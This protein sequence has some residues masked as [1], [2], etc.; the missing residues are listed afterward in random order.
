MSEVSCPTLWGLIAT[1]DPQFA[2][3]TWDQA[4][5]SLVGPAPWMTLTFHRPGKGLYSYLIH[6]AV[7]G[8]VHEVRAYVEAPEHSPMVPREVSAGGVV[9]TRGS[10][11]VWRG[12]LTLDAFLDRWAALEEAGLFAGDL[13]PPKPDLMIDQVDRLDLH[14][15]N[16][17][18][19]VTFTV[20]GEIGA[21][22]NL[23]VWR[24]LASLRSTL[25]DLLG[26]SA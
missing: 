2:H 22:P 17:A 19:E 6:V 12:G 24:L 21:P 14:A 26:D 10:L 25:P 18:E 8:P 11:H 15:S 3:R 20:W 5:R 9:L 1:F 16:G 7:T 4:V 23:R 13:A